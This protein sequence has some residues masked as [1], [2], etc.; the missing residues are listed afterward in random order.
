MIDWDLT[1]RLGSKLSGSPD[2][3]GP[4]PDALARLCDE[5]LSSVVAYSGLEP[6]GPVP[7]AEAVTRP[8]W[9]TANTASLEPLL[10]SALAGVG[11][12]AGPAGQ[13]LQLAAAVTLTVEAGAVLGLLSRKVLGQYDL[14]LVRRE[15]TPPPRLLFVAPNVGEA[16]ANLGRDGSDFLRW[17]ALHELTHAVQFGA[18]PWLRDHLG[19]VAT[20]L[21]ESLDSHGEGSRRPA[22]E[23]VGRVA[24]RAAK[25]VRG[26][27]PL[28]L[29]MDDRERALVDHMQAA[30]ALVEGHAEHVMDRADPDSIPSLSRLR[31]VM[32]EKRRAPGPLW[33]VLGKL[34]G[35]DLKMR[36]YET[37]RRFC[38]GVVDIAGVDS[39]NIAWSSPDA[40]PGHDELE[41]P[42][43]WLDRVTG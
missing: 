17:I 37:G 40:I 36:Q 14:S 20:E 1:R 2:F 29:L 41:Q 39:L 35:L 43:L 10:E 18:V 28:H 26:R 7:R 16:M 32:S 11:E 4:D 6:A 34:L 9:I 22:L 15:D 31:S 24:G 13:G 5:A 38:D 21:I 30:M 25:T 27:D 19:G 3:R 23:R 42:R 12:R 33:R 8:E